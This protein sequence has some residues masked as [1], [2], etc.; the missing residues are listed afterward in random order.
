M[1]TADT[2]VTDKADADTVPK[3]WSGL[4]GIALWF[5]FLCPLSSSSAAI[6]KE[7]QLHGLDADNLCLFKDFNIGDSHSCG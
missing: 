2:V 1:P 6:F 5:L 3:V 4:D 7:F